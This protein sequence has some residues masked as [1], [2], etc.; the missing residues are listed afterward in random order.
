V[1]S[2]NLCSAKRRARASLAAH[3]GKTAAAKPVLRVRCG[4][5]K[6]RKGAPG[7]GHKRR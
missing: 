2:A 5:G 1:N 7:K 3:N 4:K 6:G